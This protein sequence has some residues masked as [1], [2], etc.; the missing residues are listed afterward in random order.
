M[1]YRDVITIFMIIIL[2]LSIAYVIAV[3]SSL[4]FVSLVLFGFTSFITYKLWIEK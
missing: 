3:N 2:I 4:W 1:K